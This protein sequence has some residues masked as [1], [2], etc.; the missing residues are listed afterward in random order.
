MHSFWL[1]HQPS[2]FNAPLTTGG[3]FTVHFCVCVCVCSVC[4]H[5]LPHSFRVAIVTKQD[6]HTRKNKKKQNGVRNFWP[7]TV[8]T[9][10]WQVEWSLT[11][12]TL[13]EM[14]ALLFY[15]YFGICLW[16]HPFLLLLL[17]RWT[18]PVNVISPS[19]NFRCVCVCGQENQVN[20]RPL[21]PEFPFSFLIIYLFWVVF[22][23]TFNGAL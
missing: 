10:C 7:A 11:H 19:L 13:M 18:K 15:Y 2:P 22:S 9:I 6:G 3:L 4:V 21:P 16:N 23:F 8:R 20:H 5:H 17:L 12:A 1:G 14:T